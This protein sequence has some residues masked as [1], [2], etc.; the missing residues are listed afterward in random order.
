MGL[1][2]AG[3]SRLTLLTVNVVSCRFHER[4]EALPPGWV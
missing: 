2:Q 1:D 4:W 3:R